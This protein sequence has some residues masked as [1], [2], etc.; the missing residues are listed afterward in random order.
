MKLL[1]NRESK[2]ALTMAQKATMNDYKDISSLTT[3]QT[4]DQETYLKNL[5]AATIFY[6]CIDEKTGQ[7]I[8]DKIE[9]VEKYLLPVD[10]T[11]LT[12]QYYWWCQSLNPMQNIDSQED[13]DKFIDQLAEGVPASFFLPHLMKKTHQ[14]ASFAAYMA[15]TIL[16]LRHTISTL[17]SPQPSSEEEEP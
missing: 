13:Y 9:E 8:F 1:N 3:A 11:Y 2:M 15:K 12:D 7:R 10:I 5:S 4:S 16:E 17:L 6:S 14:H